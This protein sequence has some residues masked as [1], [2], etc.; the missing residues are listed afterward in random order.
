MSLSEMFVTK[1]YVKGKKMVNKKIKMGS[2][3]PKRSTA[4]KSGVTRAKESVKSIKKQTST[5]K[6]A[7]ANKMGAEGPRKSVSSQTRFRLRRSDTPVSAAETRAREL[8]A[9]QRKAKVAGARMK[10]GAEGPKG[11]N[12][13]KTTGPAKGSVA[14]AY[15][16]G[17]RGRNPIVGVKYSKP[18][19]KAS[20][21]KY[22]KR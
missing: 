11:K 18:K 10:M 4:R 5:M 12:R 7:E 15:M 17:G 16:S 3:G 9:A 22:G 1:S 13:P 19:P 8:A 2:E 20:K 14:S 6:R 21:M